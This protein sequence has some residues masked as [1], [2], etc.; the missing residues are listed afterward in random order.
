MTTKY[1][2]SDDGKTID[3]KIVVWL[4]PNAALDAEDA[5]AESGRVTADSR[6]A[7]D[8]AATG[9]SS[10]KKTNG[11]TE[12]PATA[13]AT[14]PS[15]PQPPADNSPKA[16]EAQAKSQAATLAAASES[17]A[18][19]CEECERAKKKLAAARK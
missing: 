18:P 10:T 17:G 12:S 4:E 14:T 16:V 2:R 7:D 15:R 11:E 6:P 5:A 8:D 3:G 9:K 13:K 19:F 1:H